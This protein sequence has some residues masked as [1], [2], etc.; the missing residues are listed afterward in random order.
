MPVGLDGI[1]FARK[2]G[3]NPVPR[4]QRD[5]FQDGETRI[6]MKGLIS[7]GHV[8][9]KDSFVRDPELRDF[10]VGDM[11]SKFK[12]SSWKLGKSDLPVN[13]H[14]RIDTVLRLYSR[15]NN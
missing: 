6:L 12:E 13:I 3:S 11:S 7:G 5:G 15:L 4:N 14:S 9:S 10:L 8:K 1:C 2:Q